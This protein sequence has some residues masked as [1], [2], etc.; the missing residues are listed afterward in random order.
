M[1]G[2]KVCEVTPILN[3]SDV[4]ASIL[5]FESLGWRRTFTW[6]AGGGMEDGALANAHGPP[7]FA[8]VCAGSATVFLA[9]NGQGHRPGP[10]APHL[11][12]GVWMCWYLGSTSDVDELFARAKGLGYA[13][14]TAPRDEPWHMREFHL[15][16]P[17]GHTIRIGA[18]IGD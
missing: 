3:V 13:I 5:W 9:L 16:H 12:S 1:S 11:T 7:D 4:A 17:D 10:G 6:N 2:V 14:P 18:G 15:R 8:G